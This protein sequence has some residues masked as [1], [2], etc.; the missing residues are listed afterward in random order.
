M[1]KKRQLTAFCLL[2]YSSAALMAGEVH[3]WTLDNGLHLI[4]KEDQPSM[5]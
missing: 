5:V 2:C 3:E 4:V 1:Y